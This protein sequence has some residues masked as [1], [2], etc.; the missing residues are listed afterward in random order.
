MGKEV[1]EAAS[2][3]SRPRPVQDRVQVWLLTV[4]RSLSESGT[5]MKSGR[6]S[7]RAHFKLADGGGQT[8]WTQGAP[9][10]L[11]LEASSSISVRPI[12]SRLLTNFA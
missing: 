4:S 12:S 5:P 7:H 1:S 10:R 11:W 9:A 2:P 6:P 8:T 3:S